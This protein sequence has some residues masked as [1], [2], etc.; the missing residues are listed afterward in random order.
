MTTNGEFKSDIVDISV[1]LLRESDKALLVKP[2]FREA[3]AS[4]V[5]KSMVEIAPN[6][7]SAAMTLSLPEWLAREKRFL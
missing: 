4:W 1:S 5:P 7:G 2:A 3:S 6:E